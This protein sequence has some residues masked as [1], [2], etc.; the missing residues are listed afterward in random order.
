MADSSRLGQG[1]ELSTFEAE[2]DTRNPL[3]VVDTHI[4]AEVVDS[5]PPGAAQQGT[6]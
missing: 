2:A 6:A 5:R 1:V 4:L 3:A